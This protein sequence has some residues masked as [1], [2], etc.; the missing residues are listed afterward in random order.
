MCYSILPHT[1]AFSESI[2]ICSN[3]QHVSYL[4]SENG[5]VHAFRAAVGHH[6]VYSIM[7]AYMCE[8]VGIV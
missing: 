5:V 2:G 3:Q 6:T 7:H 4:Q 8:C 1:V